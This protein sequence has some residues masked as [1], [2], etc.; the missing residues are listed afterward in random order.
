MR[1]ELGDRDI[2]RIIGLPGLVALRFPALACS[3]CGEV[4]LEGGALDTLSSAI[5]VA[6]EHRRDDLDAD[7]V[8]FLR[9]RAASGAPKVRADLWPARE[10]VA[11][12]LERRRAA[13]RSM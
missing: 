1:R 6:L 4:L 2:G 5:A 12:M 13:L 8:E 9:K 7:E 3:A 11:T 10:D